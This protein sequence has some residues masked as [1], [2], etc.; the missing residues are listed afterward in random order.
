MKTQLIKTELG[1]F[2][3]VEVPKDIED[4]VY[5]KL[6]MCDIYYSLKGKPYDEDNY[7]SQQI[8]EGN[9]EVLGFADQLEVA[10]QVVE[11]HI[12]NTLNERLTYCRDY[13]W[14]TLM[15]DRNITVFDSLSSLLKSVGIFTENPYPNP[16]TL[17]HESTEHFCEARSLYQE[18]ESNLW[19]KILILKLIK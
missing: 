10:R 19:Q 15:F 5:P 18:A 13:S 4:K 3:A 6:G 17:N 12:C 9:Y 2:L 1:E 7:C 14:N 16:I 11:T 8:P